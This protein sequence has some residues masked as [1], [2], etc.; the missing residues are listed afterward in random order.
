MR[1]ERG[2]VLPEIS[3]KRP[4]AAA[5]PEMLKMPTHISRQKA[6]ITTR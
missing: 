1:I 6:E 3:G 5:C 4:R 2:L